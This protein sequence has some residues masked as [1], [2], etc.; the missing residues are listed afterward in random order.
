[1]LECILIAAKGLDELLKHEIQ[2]ILANDKDEAPREVHLTPGQ[3]RLH[4]S[5]EEIYKL[6]LHTRIANRV[7]VVLAKGNVKSA[8]DIYTI[9]QQ[10][11]W[12]Q[13]FDVNS[14]FAV[15]FNGTN[16]EIR[17]T[18]FGGLK[19]KDAVVD[20]FVELTGR[21]PD[22]SR[23]SPDVQ[24]YGRLR[25]DKLD[26]CM[27]MSGT[28][29]HQ[30]GYRTET[31]DA[32]LKEQVAAAVL[33]RS[34]WSKNMDATLFDPMCG[35][36]T[37][38]IEAALLARNIPP[39]LARFHWGF[40][41]YL[42]HD[43]ALWAK[44]KQEAEAAIK[45][46][47]APIF[48]FDVST[49]VLDLA[50]QN[51]ENAGVSD[52][53]Q[54]KQCDVLQSPRVAESGYIVSNPP[55][56]ERLGEYVGLLPLYDG[57]GK[58]LKTHFADWHVSLLSSDERL[59]K[60]LKLR[61]TKKY[62]LNNGKLDCVLANFVL[63][64]TNCRVASENQQNKSAASLTTSQKD[65]S[66]L[67][68]PELA[69]R[70]IKNKKRLQKW[71]KREN[72]EAYRL[73]DADLPHYNFAI[74]IY[75]DHVIVQ[76]YAPPKSL[77]EA[78]ATQRLQDALLTVP[79]VLM[80]EPSKLILKRRAKQEGSNQYQKHSNTNT[81]IVVKEHGAKFYINPRDYLDVGLFLDHR[82]TRQLF[83]SKVKNKHV[84][85]LFC[86]T[87]SVSVHAAMH[88]AES[89]T[90]VDMSRTYVNWA[91]DNFELNDLIGKYANPQYMFE[92]ADCLHWLKQRAQDNFPQY[93]A[94]FI[95]PP[96]FSNSKRMDGTWDVQRD[97]I[98]L[99]KN[100]F[101]CLKEDGFIFFSNNLRNFKLDTESLAGLGIQALDLCRKT[102]PE[103]FS[104]KPNIH[105]CWEL[106]RERK[107]G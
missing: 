16:K 17:N 21:R 95:D 7:L 52:D 53:I 15:R 55:Y 30:R 88:G 1:M 70:L 43:R 92:Q 83:A 31:G 44:V 69:N 79:K 80:C 76:E 35:S 12:S 5:L 37:I 9:T 64:E 77:P 105:H 87:G 91:R 89:I 24:V 26:I 46:Q 81:R 84:L 38:A 73:Y 102:I 3:C 22:V 23:Q 78:V 49:K 14:S 62:A 10:V 59:L 99:I 29:L 47:C 27:D 57:L 41:H 51:A 11:Q 75:G 65:T 32:P 19:I 20:Q 107:H 6:N 97:H 33:M 66:S 98:G 96:S 18:Q 2:A 72:I 61:S 71:I 68:S 60:A 50:K 106:R 54:F 104:R 58:H 36:G 63:D 85:N 40:E 93:D 103:D 45:A 67:A 25:R 4:A 8:E 28:S 48:A 56:G 82:I 42:G 34:G 100:A 86:Y 94:I 101:S 90:S 13:N 74:D 39:N